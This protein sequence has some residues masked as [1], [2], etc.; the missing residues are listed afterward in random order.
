LLWNLVLWV[1]R[2]QRT[3]K[4]RGPKLN[5]FL[6]IIRGCQDAGSGP[7]FMCRVDHTYVRRRHWLTGSA[8]TRLP[9]AC[10]RE[11]VYTT[12][13]DDSAAFQ[14]RDRCKCPPGH[15]GER[16]SA[17]RFRVAELAGRADEAGRAPDR[18]GA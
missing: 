17:Q 12:F 4:T 15:V 8:I 16:L 14:V 13:Q 5:A 10:F 6:S 9:S 2:G 11:H 3:T 1:P 7:H 18:G